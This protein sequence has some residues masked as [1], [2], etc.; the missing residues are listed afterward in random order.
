MYFLLHRYKSI[1][2]AIIAV[3]TGGFFL[4]LFFTGGVQDITSPSK[5]CVAEVG[6]GCITLKDYRRELMRFSN[7][8]QN[9]QME[10]LVK[11]Q[12]LSNLV[13]QELLY[14][15]A[16]SLSLLASEREVVE[17]I[18]SDPTFQEGGLFTASRYKEVLSRSGMTPEEY[19]E[20][21]RKAISVRKL[22][23]LLTNGVYLTEEEFEANV[24]AESTL[25]SGSLYIITPSDMKDRYSPT[26][27]E[28][29]EYY[30]KNKEAFKRQESKLI[31]VWR[32]KDKERALAIYRELKEGKEPQGFQELRLPD[33]S[34]KL[35]ESLKGEAQKLTLQDRLVI[36]KQADG[37]AVIY[38]REVLPAGYEEFD[39]VKEKVKERFMEEK[40]N[41]LA[42]KKGEELAKALKEGK[43][44][45]AKALNFS[46]TPAMQLSAVINVDQKDLIR[47][48]LS[49]EKVFGPY[50]LR[51]GY[52]VI[53]LD[54]RASKEIKGEEKKEILRDV[55]SLKTQTVLTQYIEHLKKNTKIRLNKEMLGG[56]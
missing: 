12:V 27:R 38:L 21:L 20:Y 50:P 1:T 45:E 30:Q 55:L 53:L 56:G 46:D 36:T 29:L 28:L 41:S 7:L 42:L 13:A 16:K 51:Q 9:P 47:M 10:G 6:S 23:S 37:Y 2:I 35:E 11:E 25:L 40:A 8:L 43:K 22:I 17:V 4:W 54:K 5:R 52:G 31:R 3:A 34:Q 39:K 48:L 49:K 14:Q 32:E 33:E 19:E 18:K 26:E 15:K 44:P 24:L